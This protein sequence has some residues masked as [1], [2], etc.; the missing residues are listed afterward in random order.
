MCL[1]ESQ[2]T[3]A[4]VTKHLMEPWREASALGTET[5]SLLTL[6]AVYKVGV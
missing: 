5:A 2:D 6:R 3:R 1:G 4:Q